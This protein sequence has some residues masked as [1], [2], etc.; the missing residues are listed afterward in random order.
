MSLQYVEAVP[1]VKYTIKST[2]KKQCACK[3]LGKYNWNAATFKYAHLFSKYEWISEGGFLRVISN[4]SHF[5]WHQI[6]FWTVD[7]QKNLALPH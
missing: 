6:G 2:E 7:G 5:S 4:S 1:A 3:A